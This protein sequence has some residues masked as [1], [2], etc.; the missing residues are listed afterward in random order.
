MSQRQS[1]EGKLNFLKLNENECITTKPLGY[2][3]NLSDEKK[4][5][6]L[7]VYIK[8]M[9]KCTNQWLKERKKF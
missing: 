8:T 3:R 5:I 1:Q 9:R 6:A 2:T 7:C 4:I